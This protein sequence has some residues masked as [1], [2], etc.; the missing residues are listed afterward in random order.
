MRILTLCTGNICRSPMAQ[1]FLARQFPDALV[2]SAGVGALVGSPAD[3]LAVQCMADR[4]YDISGHVARQTTPEMLKESDLVLT[5]TRDQL[6]QIVRAHPWASGRVF[7]LGHWLGH[8]IQDPYRMGEESFRNCCEAIQAA[9]ATWIPR[10][11]S[12]P[13]I[14]SVPATSLT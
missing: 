9:V 11:Q 12:Q 8:D 13:S 3:P 5:A 6:N 2:E 14:S 10:I 4:G 7:R 1:A